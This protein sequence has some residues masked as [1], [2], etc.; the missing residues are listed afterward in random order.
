MFNAYL[1]KKQQVQAEKVETRKLPLW[2]D[3]KHPVNAWWVKK[4]ARRAPPEP[5]P[6]KT[7][8]QEDFFSAC[9]LTDLNA[10]R[11]KH[12]A[13]ENHDS[14]DLDC[15]IIAVEGPLSASS[16]TSPRTPK[17]L[18][19]QLSRDSAAVAR[20]RIRFSAKDEEG[21]G[22]DSESNT[23]TSGVKQGALLN[24]DFSSLLGQR[25]KKH[26][27]A[28]TTVPVIKN[29]EEYC[30]TT[31]AQSDVGVK[32][33]H[34]ASEYP[35]TFR[36]KK[37]V[38]HRHCHTFKLTGGE[39]REF[40]RVLKT[41]LDKTSRRLQRQMKSCFVQLVKLTSQEIRY[42]T[43]KRT[44]IINQEIHIDDDISIMQVDIPE[45]SY[46]AVCHKLP[47]ASADGVCLQTAL[48][49]CLMRCMWHILHRS[50]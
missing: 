37:A 25:L 14:V 22:N 13:E 32:L 19:S 4:R 35:V 7:L 36:K 3:S 5:H 41:G 9:G 50:T 1:R 49:W 39:R 48:L 44:T 43:I 20:K 27:Q 29:P 10:L 34:R 46:R 17:S 45:S 2:D 8:K 30:K 31:R 33:R 47:V 15:Q 11:L 26:M 28:E 24:I 21:S 42:W 23:A 12:E 18:M 6:S 38:H 40:L 16:V